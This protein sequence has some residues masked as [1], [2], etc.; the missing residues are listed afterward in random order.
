MALDEAERQ[1]RVKLSTTPASA[2]ARVIAT[3]VERHG[4][5]AGYLEAGGLREEQLERLRER[6][7]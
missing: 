2:M 7:R 1:R 4:S 6:L 5:V 3:I